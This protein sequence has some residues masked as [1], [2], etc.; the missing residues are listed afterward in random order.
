M[1][2]KKEPIAISR[3]DKMG[4]RIRYSDINSI[5][6]VMTTCRKSE[7]GTIMDHNLKRES[8]FIEGQLLFSAGTITFS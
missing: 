7:Q 1:V 6:G 2:H 4:Q 5:T 8:V 3:P